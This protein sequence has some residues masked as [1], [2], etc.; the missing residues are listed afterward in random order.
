MSKPS[1]CDKQRGNGDWGGKIGSGKM[2]R[3]EGNEEVEG[4]RHY[5]KSKINR[6]TPERETVEGNLLVNIG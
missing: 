2:E 1:E 4:G 3:G 5:K 6:K